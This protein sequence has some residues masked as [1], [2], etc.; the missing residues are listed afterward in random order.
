MSSL[1]RWVSH[2]RHLSW[3]LDRPSEIPLCSDLDECLPLPDLTGVR[4]LWPNRYSWPR[5]SVF[6]DVLK[7]ALRRL[8]R[9]KSTSISAADSHWHDRG[10]FP[11]PWHAAPKVGTVGNPRDPNDIRG[12]IFEVWRGSHSVRCA[13]DYSDY[14]LVSTEILNTV[15]AYFKF[16]PSG[17]FPRK[18]LASGYF[19]PRPRL[20]AKARTE[21][22]ETRIEKDI[23]VY[24]RFGAWTDSQKQRERLVRTV[25]ESS[26]RFLGGFDTI[27]FPAYLKELMR[28]R[29]ALDARGQGPVT[30]RLPEA[31][32]LGA[33]VVSAPP[34][35]IFPESLGDGTHY[36]ASRQDYGDV[37]EL[38]TDLL[39][40]EERMNAIRNNAMG[41]FDRN[42]S[43]QSA[44]R[45]I[46]RHTVTL[47]G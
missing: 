42:F 41:F 40:D 44:A 13:Y 22:L 20:L 5:G 32:A 36:V 2:A 18:V 29:I 26:L 8:V 25:R 12:E 46:I 43:P 17:D 24:G 11:V 37:V 35:C 3:Y 9:V 31:M 33:V 21:V 39:N 45:R 34:A 10:G 30:Y 7:N 38:C 19:A 47:L 15:D 14:P 23:D 1:R 6:L 28:S 4:I 16:L 27:V